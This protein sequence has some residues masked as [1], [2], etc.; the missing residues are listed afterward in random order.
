MVVD[1]HDPSGRLADRVISDSTTAATATA[2]HLHS[3][4]LSRQRGAG[5][6]QPDLGPGAWSAADIGRT[7]QVADPPADGVADPS[8]P[9]AA[10]SASRPA[11]IPGPSSRM[12]TLTVA[13]SSSTSTHA[14]ARSRRNV[15]A[16]C[17]SPALTAAAVSVTVRSVRRTGSAG[18][19]TDTRADASRASVHAQVEL[20]GQRRRD[21]FRR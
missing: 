1:D 6:P 12:V 5:H 9:S 11:A 3:D 4:T 21:G 2:G 17:R 16:R 13:P 20:A 15:A 18:V 7:A 8:R 14:L 10:A 19:I